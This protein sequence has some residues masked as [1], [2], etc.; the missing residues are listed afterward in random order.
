MNESLYVNNTYPDG[1]GLLLGPYLFSFIYEIKKR[2]SRGKSTLGT[3]VISTQSSRKID[4]NYITGFTDG[5]GCFYIGLSP[6]KNYNSGYRVKLSFQIGLHEK[7]LGLLKLIISY[8]GVGKISKL[9]SNSVLYR[10]TSIDELKVIIDHF[11]RYPLISYK[12][13][14]YLLFKQ[15]FE[16]V[17]KKEHFS[18]EGLRKIVAI[19]ASINLKLSSNLKNAFPNIVPVTIPKIE[20]RKI[21]NYNWIAGFTD[22]EGCFFIAH[23]KSQAS[24]LGETV[25]LKFIL[26]QHSRDENLLKNLIEIFGCGRFVAKNTKEYGEF[27]VE[28]YSD[29]RDKIIPF[30]E[31]YPLY[32][33]KKENY[34]D[35]KKVSEL[36]NNKSHLTLEGLEQ[37]KQIKSGMN[38]YRK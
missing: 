25:W 16:L 38:K 35:F 28:K 5:E 1:E 14:D 27:I 30:F 2:N 33:I 34:L 7:D 32:G 11:D 18:V 20:D 26:T 17:Q 3:R 21:L 22:A 8:F 37:I 6:D 31:K 23:K 24:K 12:Y 10:V 19:K 36:I 4:P 15:A 29:I 9:A 13:K